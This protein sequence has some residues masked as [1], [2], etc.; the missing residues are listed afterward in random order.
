M[1]TSRLATVA[2]LEMKFTGEDDKPVF[3]VEHRRFF[4]LFFVFF[5][6]IVSVHAQRYATGFKVKKEGD[7]TW[8]TVTH[9]YKGAT[10][11]YQ[12]LLVPKGQKAPSHPSDVP[13]IYTPVDR[14]VCTSTTHIPHLD[15][16]GV[17]NKLVGFP[18]TDYISSETTRKL[19]D[20][21]NVKE[22]GADN[23]LNIELLY[24]LRP[25]M[26]MG[27]MMTADLGQMKKIRELGIPVV[28]NAEYME[29]DA[30]G[31]AEWI[32]FTALFFGKEKVADSVFTM[33]EKE[34]KA[35]LSK[36][37]G[38]KQKPS[39]LLGTVYGDA[40][41]MPGGQN[42][43]AKLLE[44]AGCNY[45]WATDSTT[46]WLEISF[47]AVYSKAKNADLW[48]VGSFDTFEE[49]KAADKRYELFKPFV[50]KQIYN[51]NARKGAKGGNDFLEL[52]YLR[53]DIILKDLVKIGHPALLP[54]HQLYFHRKLR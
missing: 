54:D 52:G 11:G 16:L 14:I 6:L 22:L 32:K 45:L 50:T 53:P 38:V 43:A 27:Y 1:T 49:L 18:S 35:T 20:S 8:V 13:V 15:Y 46:G 21:G 51:Y 26:V 36:L 17:S 12:Y 31:R 23:A 40:W 4:V 19:V 37:K 39:V 42:Y 24:Q 28:I 25:S 2:A 48:I 30:L 44:D 3:H 47:E 10:S 7:V 33:I 29:R 41:F 9:P 5:F 34:Y